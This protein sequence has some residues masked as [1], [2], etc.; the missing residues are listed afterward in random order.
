MT[1]QTLDETDLKILRILQDNC[2]VTT[3]ELASQIHLSSTPT[4]DRMK[5][6]EAMG[7][8]SKFTAI[9]DPEKLE[10]GFVVYCNIL[11]KQINKDVAME[12]M[13]EV[14]SWKE[15]TECYNVSGGCDYM[16]KVYCQSMAKYQQFVVEKVGALPYVGRI[17]S[18]FVMS[19]LKITYGIPI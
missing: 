9:L 3:R 10:C 16:M 17:N 4:F 8:I 1:I 11:M 6:L 7:F 13:N 18:I 12:F 5:R 19:T 14:Q 2:R 15:V